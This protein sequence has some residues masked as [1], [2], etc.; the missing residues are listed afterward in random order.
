M[1]A[2][3]I[4]DEIIRVAQIIIFFGNMMVFSENCLSQGL[5]H[6]KLGREKK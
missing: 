4:H 3:K 2:A 6:L 5:I 1:G